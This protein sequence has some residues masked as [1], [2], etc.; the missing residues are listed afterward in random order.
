MI[1]W[2]EDKCC[3]MTGGIKG[4]KGHN[5]IADLCIWKCPGA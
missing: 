3:Y 2:G 1:E 5:T 4:H